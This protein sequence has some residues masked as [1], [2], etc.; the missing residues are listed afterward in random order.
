MPEMTPPI[1]PMT[2]DLRRRQE[3]V[4]DS[5]EPK[6]PRHGSGA[7]S[8]THAHSANSAPDFRLHLGTVSNSDVTR[9]G[10]LQVCRRSLLEHPPGTTPWHHTARQVAHGVAREPPGVRDE[11]RSLPPLPAR[12]HRVGEAV[13]VEYHGP[14]RALLVA[15][16]DRKPSTCCRGPE[17]GV[18][19][20]PCLPLDFNVLGQC[21][22]TA[23]LV[24]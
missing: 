17:L 4:V 8:L 10:C 14:R 15:H 7:E 11:R 1:T 16:D 3:H 5:Y 23:I 22:S 21:E 13:Q 9:R 24:R 6:L 18:A 20:S 19:A 12:V 2:R